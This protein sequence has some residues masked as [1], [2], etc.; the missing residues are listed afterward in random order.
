[1]VLTVTYVCLSMQPKPAKLALIA[2]R[3]DLPRHIISQC[4][5]QKRDLVVVAFE[6]Q[7]DE[8]LTYGVEHFW[9]TLGAIGKTLEELKQ[10]SVQEIVIAG[11]MKRPSWSEL[12][13]DWTGTKFLMR[14]GINSL[15]DDGLLSAVVKLLEEQGF[16]LI[17]PDHFIVNLMAEEGQL[18]PHKPD[19]ED[20]ADIDYGIRILKTI[21][22]LDIGQAV[23]VQRNIVLGV[24]AIE[25]TAQLIKRCKD[26]K[27]SGP[28]GVLVKIAKPNQ[29]LKVDLPTIGPDTIDQLVDAGLKGIAIEAHKTQ[30]L[31]RSLTL[32]KA[33]EHG[34]YILGV[35]VD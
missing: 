23:V 18:T 25:G 15:G 13:L 21:G 1:M 16:R 7:T 22:P 3:G 2:G 28:G 19:E 35:K 20:C 9:T 14:V 24:E 26:L 31:Q 34:I 8:D 32:E 30:I 33:N 12:K 5:N 27:R 11:A 4:Q 17:T 10:R 29:S 6:G